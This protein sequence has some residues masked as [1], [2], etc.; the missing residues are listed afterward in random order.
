MA[1]SNIRD[2]RTDVTVKQIAERIRFNGPTAE[3]A[4]GGT[5]FFIGAG[6]SV[7]AGIPGVAGVA[8]GELPHIARRLGVDAPESADAAS[9]YRALRHADRLVTCLLPSVA[10]DQ[11]AIALDEQ[12]DWARVYD[13]I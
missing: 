13:E 9:V 1:A 7:T 3:G 4:L 8:R 2:P 11:D 10:P 6:C 12:I 5:V